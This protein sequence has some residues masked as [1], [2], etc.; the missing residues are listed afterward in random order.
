MGQHLAFGGQQHRAAV[1]DTHMIAYFIQ[2]ERLPHST[3]GNLKKVLKHL[4]CTDPGRLGKLA[5]SRKTIA[6]HAL[7]SLSHAR[8]WF[9]YPPPRQSLF[10]HRGAFEGRND[11]KMRELYFCKSDVR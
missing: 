8:L 2:R 6:R 7:P 3:G 11:S 10:K 1:V 5:M 9:F 4:H